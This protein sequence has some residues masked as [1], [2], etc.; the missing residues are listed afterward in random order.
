MWIDIIG[1][2][3]AWFARTG[4]VILSVTKEPSH[5]VAHFAGM[6]VYTLHIK[7]AHAHSPARPCAY[8]PSRRLWH[9]VLCLSDA[10]TVHASLALLGPTVHVCVLLRGRDSGTW[11]VSWALCARFPVP[12]AKAQSQQS[13][14]F[15]HH[16]PPTSARNDHSANG[17]GRNDAGKVNAAVPAYTHARQENGGFAEDLPACLGGV[18]ADVVFRSHVYSQRGPAQGQWRATA[19]VRECGSC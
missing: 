11:D 6:H 7:I 15:F 10:L 17:N 8:A 18:Q 19:R 16:L 14:M 2:W 5:T 12:P 4:R 3:R 13:H 1:Q 9:R